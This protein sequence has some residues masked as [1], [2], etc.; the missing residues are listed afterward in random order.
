MKLQE[1]E[2]QWS[3]PPPVKKTRASNAFESKSMNENISKTPEDDNT[4]F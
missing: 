4:H 2:H 1:P 3:L